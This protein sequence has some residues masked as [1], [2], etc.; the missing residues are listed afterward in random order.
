MTKT[1]TANPH[2]LSSVITVRVTVRCQNCDYEEER[3]RTEEECFDG[4]KCPNCDEP[5]F[6]VTPSD[7]DLDK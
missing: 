7:E 2:R 5:M 6:E 3:S 4:L 1:K